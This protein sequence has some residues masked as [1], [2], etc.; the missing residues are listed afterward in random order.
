MYSDF[1]KWA[2]FIDSF[3]DDFFF[4]FRENIGKFVGFKVVGGFDKERFFCRLLNMG[5]YVVFFDDI[6]V[7]HDHHVFQD[8]AQFSDIAWPTVIG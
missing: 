8:I 4:D 2:Q 5:R 3:A 1:S 7:G 6:A